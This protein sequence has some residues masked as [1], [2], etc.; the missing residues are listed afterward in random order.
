MS[1]PLVRI[2]FG[3]QPKHLSKVCARLIRLKTAGASSL[4]CNE[5]HRCP[6]GGRTTCESCKAIDVRHWHRQGRLAAGQQ[7]SSGWTRGG[8]PSGSITVRTESNA[9]M[10]IYRYRGWGGSDWE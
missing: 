2:G 8:E 6:W 3:C 10:L 9:V 4:R 1:I 5:T 7:F